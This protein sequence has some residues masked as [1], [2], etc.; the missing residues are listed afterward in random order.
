MLDEEMW[1]GRFA[2]EDLR[3]KKMRDE[4]M[5]DKYMSFLSLQAIYLYKN[6]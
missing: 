5:W 1:T 4:E 3:A 2:D 6:W